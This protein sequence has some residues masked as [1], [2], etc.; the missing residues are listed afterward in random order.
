MVE[1]KKIKVLQ[2]SHG[3]APG[4]IEAFLLNVFENIDREKIQMDFAVAADG[5]QFHEDR[6]LNQG[7]KVYH[8]SDLNGMKNK[9]KHFYRLIK[10]LKKEGPFDVVHSHI[11]FMNGINLLAA[12]IAGVPIR[13]SHAHSTHSAGGV[14]AKSTNLVKVYRFFM[15]FLITSFSNKYLGCSEEANK[16]MYGKTR[17]NKCTFIPNGIDLTKFKSIVK[18]KDYELINFIAI[19]RFVA[20]KNCL[21]MAEVLFELSKIRQDFKMNWIGVGPLEEKVKKY[22]AKNDMEKYISFLGSRNDIADLLS[23][24]DFMI[25]PSLWEG[26]PVTLIEAQATNT[27]C[28]ISNIITEE[29]DVGLCTKISLEKSAFEWAKELNSHIENKTFKNELNQKKLDFFNIKNLAIQMEKI[30]LDL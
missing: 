17:L 5:K 26:L 28:F 12:Y 9:I 19:G 27:P 21:F 23:K 8:T 18:I 7:A 22:I 11:D 2:V 13:I 3:L 6:V 10:L 16:Y 24:S 4:G 1:R 15:R 20:A 30:Y 25:F 29:A 14:S